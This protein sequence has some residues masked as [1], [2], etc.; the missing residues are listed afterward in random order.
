[1]PPRIA[2]KTV[3]NSRKSE[4]EPPARAAFSANFCRVTGIFCPLERPGP[5]HPEG[6][7][8]GN[9]KTDPVNMTSSTQSVAI[10][11]T[12]LETLTMDTPT[13]AID[14]GEPLSNDYAEFSRFMRVG[15][16]FLVRSHSVG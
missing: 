15:S 6:A 13:G 3:E 16:I 5:A 14:A 11:M 2:H 12:E 8:S 4:K 7:Y 9:V 1:M 10:R